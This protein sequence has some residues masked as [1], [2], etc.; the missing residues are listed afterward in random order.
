METISATEARSRLFDLL[1]DSLNK[2]RQF[3][4]P[5]KGGSV[6]MISE[7]EYDSLL[8][9]AHLL[10]APGFL[11]LYQKAKKQIRAGKTVPMDKVFGR[12]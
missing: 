7:E 11:K 4:I 5:Y 9:T 1:K 12:K 2:S 3:R 8:E 6:V 10:T